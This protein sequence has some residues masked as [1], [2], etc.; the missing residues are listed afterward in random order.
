MLV[1]MNLVRERD[2]YANVLNWILA[3]NV[4]TLTP[5]LTERIGDTQLDAYRILD[6][7]S[8][9]AVVERFTD[10]GEVQTGVY[11]VSDIGHGA[12]TEWECFIKRAAEAARHAGKFN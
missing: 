11:R 5:I 1:M 9:I 10:T 2:F 6:D 3:T 7:D 4:M 8:A 12:H